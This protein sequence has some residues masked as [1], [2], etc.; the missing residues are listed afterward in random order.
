MNHTPGPWS[1]EKYKEPYNNHLYTYHVLNEE[2]LIVA[3]CGTGDFEIPDNARLIAA[4]PEMLEALEA[5]LGWYNG[6]TDIEAM[7]RKAI[8]KAKGR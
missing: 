7:I 1:V 2:S 6:P 8:L 5:V 4:A 3:K